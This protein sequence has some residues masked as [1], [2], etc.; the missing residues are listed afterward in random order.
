M[1]TVHSTPRW[2]L[3]FDGSCDTCSRIADQARSIVGDTIEV[4]SLRSVEVREWQHAAFGAN[5]PFVP[6][7]FMVIDADVRAWTGSAMTA[8]LTRLLG[9]RR[10]LKLA[11]VVGSEAIAFENVHNPSR[12]N[13][14]RGLVG[15]GAAGLLLGLQKQHLIAAAAGEPFDS[16]RKETYLTTVEAAEHALLAA[17]FDTD[18][19]HAFADYMN[20]HG[21]ARS[22]DAEF[23]TAIVEGRKVRSAGVETWLSTSALDKVAT[24]SVSLESESKQI[25]WYPRLQ[26]RNNVVRQLAFAQDGTVIEDDYSVEDGGMVEPAG[27]GVPGRCT[28]CHWACGVIIGGV[29]G[30]ACTTAC[31]AGCG[32]F[33]PACAPV[34]GIACIALVGAPID[35]GCGNAC[36]YIDWC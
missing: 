31:A 10:A 29:V 16:I 28:I 23:V 36:D 9:P 35:G 3:G 20:A 22:V 4:L 8:R 25:V 6:T 21:Y 11:R 18:A 33:A 24:I 26:P 13:L 14:M 15:T 2:I 1:N 30:S 19:Y 34:C 17:Q 32:P 7:L 5:P 27:W 12:R